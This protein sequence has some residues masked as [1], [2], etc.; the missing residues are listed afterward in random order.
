MAAP[1]ISTFLIVCESVGTTV[2]LATLD[3]L[4]A[5]CG[6][7][8]DAYWGTS[9]GDY[10]QTTDSSNTLV[11]G[12]LLVVVVVV[13]GVHREVHR[14]LQIL[15]V[16]LTI[17]LFVSSAIASFDAMGLDCPG[18]D[19]SMGCTES[20]PDFWMVPANYCPHEIANNVKCDVKGNANNLQMC[21]RLG[22]APLVNGAMAAWFMRTLL[23]DAVRLVL[24]GAGWAGLLQ[25]VEASSSAASPPRRRTTNTNKTNN[26]V[27]R[28]F[29][30]SGGGG[31]G[32]VK[33]IKTTLARPPNTRLNERDTL[34]ATDNVIRQSPHVRKR[35]AA[36]FNIDF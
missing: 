28:P 3:S 32:E 20:R 36:S 35:P 16:I 1:S 2:F 26:A 14:S 7:I 9:S 23:V 11:R 33:E 31:G 15:Y 17:Y 25:V 24:V 5:P 27:S 4:S 21:V 34:L 22:R 19:N 8:G 29:N 18:A 10:L 12:L 30:D 6:L 13:F